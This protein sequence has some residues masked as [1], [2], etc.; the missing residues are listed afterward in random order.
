M[1]MEIGDRKK[2][3]VGFITDDID[4]KAMGTAFYMQRLIEEYATNFK[5][6]IDLVLIH[7]EGK[8]VVPVCSRARRIPIKTFK[9]PKWTGITSFLR[10]FFTC[11]EEFDI[12]HFPRPKLFPFFWRLRAKKFV[13]TFHDAPEK[14]S[15]RFRTP[16][17]YIF[18]WF[19][20]FWGKY[21]IDAAI[22]DG[23]FPA[24][25]MARYFGLRR[26]Q[27]FGIRLAGALDLRPL[28]PEEIEPAKKK[29]REKYGIRFPYI[30]QVARLVPHKNVHRV[31]EAFGMLQEKN[32]IPHQLV[33]LGG[34]SHAPAYDAMVE[35]AIS[36]LPQKDA[37]YIAPYIES[38]DMSAVY[39]LADM[40]VQAG[41][42]D[43]FSIP[44]VDA[45]QSGVAIV[46]SNRSVFP[47]IV[48][49]AAVLVDPFSSADIARGMAQLIGDRDLR[50]RLIA[51][52]L[53]KAKEY[54]WTKAAAVTIGVYRT[55]LSRN[56]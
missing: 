12:I 24:E 39:N 20:K 25:N 5:D 53:A 22:A 49:D 36:A 37:C 31:V 54:S 43:G 32:S 18:E 35:R 46:T 34:K 52:G 1:S 23:D 14:G 51:R 13:V 19:I 45:L 41:T 27:A 50:E 7:R 8:C 21:H 47:E 44:I 33:I 55:V 28:R 6:D 48:G 3:K 38:E 15:P 42:S 56:L 4:R 30:L 40:F 10:F 29:L 2:I 16:T 26:E 9:L 11:K 17:N